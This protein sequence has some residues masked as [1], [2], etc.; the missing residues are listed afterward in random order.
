MP[1][2]SVMHSIL[3]LLYQWNLCKIMFSVYI[4]A[5]SLSGSIINFLSGV[6]TVPPLLLQAFVFG[7]MASDSQMVPPFLHFGIN[8]GDSGTHSG[9]ACVCAGCQPPRVGCLHP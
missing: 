3:G 5:I 2:L 7:K 8:S 1:L 4:V 6:V 9:V